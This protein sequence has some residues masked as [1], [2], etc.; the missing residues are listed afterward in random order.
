MCNE[1]RM[2][3]N[4]T[5]HRTRIGEWRF[6]WRVWSVFLKCRRFWIFP[7]CGNK[8]MWSTL[9]LN[10]ERIHDICSRKCFFN[11]IK[12]LNA[13]LW[14][15]GEKKCRVLLHELLLLILPKD[16][17]MN[18]TLGNE[19]YLHYCYHFSLKRFGLKI[20][21]HGQSIEKCFG[22]FMPT[23]SPALRILARTCFEIISGTLLAEKRITTTESP[24]ESIVSVVSSRLSPFS[25]NSLNQHYAYPFRDVFAARSKL[26][27]VRVEY[28]KSID[29]RMS[30]TERQFFGSSISK[31]TG[32]LKDKLKFFRFLNL[33]D[34]T[35]NQK[36]QRL[37][38]KCEE[39]F[40]EEELIGKRNENHKQRTVFYRVRHYSS[41][42]TF[43][44]SKENHFSKHGAGLLLPCISN[45][46]P[47]TIKFY[48]NKKLWIIHKAIR[49]IGWNF[50][51]LFRIF[52]RNQR[53]VK[54]PVFSGYG[55]SRNH[56]AALYSI[57]HRKKLKAYSNGS[58]S[59]CRNSSSNCWLVLI[60]SSV[61]IST[62]SRMICGCIITPPLARAP[63]HET[64]LQWC[65]AESLTK[66]CSEQMSIWPIFSGSTFPGSS[67]SSSTSV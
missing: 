55:I 24:Y 46:L 53:F 29:H 10:T 30:F 11:I 7:K 59:I 64:R 26:D 31:C 5:N 14:F 47:R 20:I 23:I 36:N 66:T 62:F 25:Q 41:G 13:K 40:C 65:Y 60:L 9:F 2:N 27:M 19:E 57:F 32:K 17:P 34:R 12:L 52:H 21:E 33:I 44:Y 39:V 37:W 15:L 16:E 56:G 63:M 42:R 28:S 22:M 50:H 38:L 48:K 51:L 61:W 4:I 35:L 67:W 3:I 54:S 18:Q 8:P 58:S 6:S 49:R 45:S 1:C 43:A